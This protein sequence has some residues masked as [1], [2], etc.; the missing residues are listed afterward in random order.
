MSFIVDLYNTFLYQPLF[1][2]LV[3]LYQYI[4]GKDFGLAVIALTILIRIALYP[5]MTKSIKSQKALSELQPKIRQIQERFKSD[6]QQQTREMMALY[7]R[8]KFNPF[9]GF[10]PILIQL[11]LLIA[12]YQVF[13]KGLNPGEMNRLYGFVANPGAVDPYFFGLI[14]LAAPSVILALLVGATQ[15]IQVKMTQAK[16]SPKEAGQP[17]SQ[18]SSMF[19]KQMLYFFPVFLTIIFI[20]LPAALALYIVATN[21]FSIFQQYFVTRPKPAETPA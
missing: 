19:Q 8:E 1:N 6:K 12:L 5:L 3:L 17:M 14:N 20:K 18:F 21:L 16:A 11:P 10:W 2:G 15:F 7:R 4:P 9:S 13:W